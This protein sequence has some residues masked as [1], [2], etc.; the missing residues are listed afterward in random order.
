ME[1]FTAKLV[2]RSG[3]GKM[4]KDLNI[5]RLYDFY[6]DLLTENQAN[7]I[8]LYYNE[9]LSLAEIAEP[10]GISRQ[11]VRD[12]LVRGEHQ[13]K[14]YENK[15]GL[16]KRFS[17]IEKQ[18]GKIKEDIKKLQKYEIDYVKSYRLRVML[19]ELDS[20]IDKIMDEV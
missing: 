14:E 15:L 4:G 19:E 13:L 17:K 2:L 10:A 3:G 6:G 18:V 16:A 20:E 5:S 9:D 7:M 11:G 1:T 12:A 8:D